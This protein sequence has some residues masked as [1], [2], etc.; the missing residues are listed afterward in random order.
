MK[1]IL[2]SLRRWTLP[3]AIFLGI[4]GHAFFSQFAFL[5]SWLLAVML[6][7]TF[8][9]LRPQE[10]R[11]HALHFRL[12]GVQAAGCLLSW[13]LL[14][15]LDPVLAQS[16]CLCFL[17]PTAAG[18][19]PITAMLGGNVGFLTTYLFLSNIAVAVGAPLLVPLISPGHSDLPFLPSMLHVFLRVAPILLAPLFL[20]WAVRW[21][22][23]K[24]NSAIGRVSFLSYYLWAAMILVLIS[25]TFDTL[26]APGEKSVALE[27]GI[28]AAG[29]AVCTMLF[30]IGRICGARQGLGLSSGQAFGQKNLLFGMWLV[31]QYLDPFV[32]ICLT[33]YSICQNMF[34]AWQ[35]WR[36]ER[37]REPGSPSAG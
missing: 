3:I 12:L 20:A 7:L 4:F 9:R 21:A 37:G 23:P 5:A 8:S 26:F 28:S 34:N 17:I 36:W 19:V 22:A 33:A 25:S 35:I 27:L 32:L 2:A 6:F 31:F 15:P 18:A 14:S 16:A 13:Y 24:V 29:A 30:C 11:F 1:N 10:L